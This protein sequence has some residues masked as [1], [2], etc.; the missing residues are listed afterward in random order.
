MVTIGAAAI[1]EQA[2]DT[3]NGMIV[4]DSKY[5][6]KLK[7]LSNSIRKNNTLASLQLFH[8]GA[9]EILNLIIKK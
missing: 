2:S 3:F 4:G 7:Q 5:L 8:V 6:T 9:Q 1:S